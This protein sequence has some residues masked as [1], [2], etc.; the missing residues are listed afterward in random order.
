M[1]N[2][3]SV[4]IPTLGRLDSL[5]E[6]LESL[7]A[8]DPLPDQT[9][10]V[11]GDM[12]RSA[13]GI[14]SGASNGIEG[15]RYLHSAAGLTHQRNR[16]LEE[17]TGDVTVFLDDDVSVPR[18]VFARLA[19]YLTDTSVVGLAARIVEPSSNAVGGKESAIRAL[20]PGG[21]SEGSFTRFGYPRRI[22]HPDR[23]MDVEIMQGCFMVARTRHAREVGFDETLTGYALA[24]DE[25]FSFRLSRLGRIRYVPSIVVHHH[26]KGFAGRDRR[27]FGRQVVVNRSYLF[28]KN[29][30]QTLLARIQFAALIGVLLCHRVINLDFR[31]ALGIVDGALEIVRS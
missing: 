25:D 4:V 18:D 15:L 20:L 17:V 23:S 21:G 7:S 1:Q 3:F 19:S 22:T 9:I 2:T 16:G 11:D 14:V 8:C 28:K 30:P 13:E 26:N 29:F 27:A 10:V 6:T 24:E 31:G 12:D 5:A